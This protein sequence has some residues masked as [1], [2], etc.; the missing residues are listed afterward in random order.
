MAQKIFVDLPVKNLKKST[1]F[2]GSLALRSM[3][4]S[5]MRPQRAW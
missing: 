2:S 5:P 1:D 4:N 3:P